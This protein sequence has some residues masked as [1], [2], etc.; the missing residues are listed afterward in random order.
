MTDNKKQTRGSEASSDKK[1]FSLLNPVQEIDQFCL[2]ELPT[3]SQV[4]GRVYHA[5]TLTENRNLLCIDDITKDVAV[6][7]E[8]HWVTPN[9]YPKHI[10]NIISQLTNEFKGMKSKGNKGL[11]HNG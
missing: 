3:Y 2:T 10:N 1:P 9:V 11:L 5:I 8:S 6:E 4:F 7:L